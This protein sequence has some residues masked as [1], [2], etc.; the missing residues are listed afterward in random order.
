MWEF[1]HSALKFLDD[2]GHFM[3]FTW[4]GQAVLLY[5]IF[6]VLVFEF[7]EHVMGVRQ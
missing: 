1:R 2:I 6:F 5:F 4:K 7:S 3:F